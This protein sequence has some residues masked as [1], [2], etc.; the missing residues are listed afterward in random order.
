[1]NA[2]ITRV[3]ERATEQ[4]RQADEELAGGETP[5]PLHGLPIA[6]K[7]LQLTSGIR[8][9]FGSRIYKE[10]IPTNDSCWWNES[11]KPARSCWEHQYGR[12]RSRFADF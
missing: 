11:G 4:A 3:A 2:I 5:G 1:M 10:F 9:T 6:H 12:V 8:T 7:D